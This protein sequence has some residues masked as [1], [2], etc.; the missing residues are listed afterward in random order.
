[1]DNHII[2]PLTEATTDL[3]IAM[4]QDFFA[5]DGY[6]FDEAA[7]KELT[8]YFLTHP[9]AGQLFM[10]Y[11]ETETVIGFLVLTFMLSFEFGGR[12][13]FLDELYLNDRAR[14]KGYGKYAV[15]FVKEYAAENGLK[16][17]FLEVEH[18]NERARRLYESNGFRD[19]HRDLMI[20]HHSE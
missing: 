6:P 4:K 18:H 17:I 19:H 13:A 10:I 20:Y 7:A 9:E 14:G 3:F 15:N 12:V 2:R 5:I 8:R 1:M 16:V 11:D